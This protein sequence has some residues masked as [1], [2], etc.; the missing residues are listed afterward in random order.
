VTTREGGVAWHALEP[1][2]VV[3]HLATD[4]ERGLTSPEAR[5]R[6][7]LVGS[8]RVADQPET[9]L[10]RLAL[11]QFSGLVVGLLLAA[12]AI[13]WVLGEHAE[14]IAILAALVLNAGIGFVSEWRA[15]VSLARLRALAVPQALVRRGGQVASVAAADLVPGDV[16]V[17]EAGSAVPAD[18]RLLRSAALQ[19]SEAA[20]TGESAAVWKDATASLGSDTPLAD[21][22]TMVYLGTTVLSG[23][24]VGVITT[25]GVATELGRIGQL[26]ALAGP[27]A[28]PLERQVEALGQRLI[29]LATAI[30]AVV[31]LAGVLH[32]QPVGLMLETAI[33]LAVAAVPEGLP[34][35]VSLALAAGLWRLARRGA[36]V[37]RLAAVETLGSTTVICADKTGTMTENQM[38]VTTIRLD[39]RQVAVS[40]G[41]RVIVGDLTDQGGRAVSPLVDPHLQLLLTAAALCNDAS[42]RVGSDGVHLYGDPTEAALLV[43]AAKAGLAAADIAP[44]WPRRREIPFDPTRRM[45]AT[46]HDM[47][48]GG[49]ALLA[50]GA[51]AVILELSTRRHTT[52]GPVPMSAEDRAR[53]LDDNRGMAREGLRVLALA[54][55]PIDAIETATVADLVF[56]GFV[57]SVDP[58]RP[59]VREAIA[60]C[61]DAG[62][63]TIMLTGDQQLTAQTVGR[64]LGLQPEAVRSRVS[65]EGKLALVAELQ[66]HGEIVAMTGDGVNDAPA[67]ARADIGVAM[68]RHGTDVARESADLVLTDDNFAT[69]VEAVKEGRI[70]YANLRK[71]IHFLFSCNLSEI[72]T[73]FVAILL[74]YP[75]PLLPLQILWVNLVTDILPAVALIRDPAEH[76]VMRLPPRDRTEALITWRFVARVL[77]EGALLAAGVLSVYLW[78]VWNQGPGARASSM[79][80]T[81]LVLI[82]P[83]QALSCRSERLNWWRL[84]PNWWVPLSLLAL[85]GAQWLTLEPGPLARLLGTVP[86]TGADWLVLTLGVLWPVTVMEA[87]KAWARAITLGP[88]VPTGA[89]P[90]AARPSRTWRKD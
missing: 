80:F 31:G 47:P 3:G 40:G 25:T 42:L 48:D 64:Q 53:F 70:I 4:P 2:A 41:G 78:V 84:R 52:S 5:R 89:A 46:F 60:A 38:T 56:L 76:D 6:L 7:R 37:R 61:R 86:L 83:F 50:K 79:A 11:E 26:V 66:E 90:A 23:S 75:A 87:R 35:V 44:A 43:V 51:P 45:M 36:L 39:D 10:W 17:L 77:G 22:A 81:A 74:G 63:R 13:A 15:R 18:A 24:G 68:G 65:P 59:S 9:P 20:L 27:R 32:G 62:I 30:C 14:A 34:A 82:H 33:S 67:L 88:P 55:R 1:A 71:V 57:G 12:S 49:S 8:N 19:V 73:I 16:I 69:I 85:L 72:L 54:W 21:R 58:V 28:T 29:V